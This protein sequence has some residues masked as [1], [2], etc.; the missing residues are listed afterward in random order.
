MLKGSSYKNFKNDHFLTKAAMAMLLERLRDVVRPK[1]NIGVVGLEPPPDKDD[2]EDDNE[3][4]DPPPLYTDL[5]GN[6]G[7]HGLNSMNSM[8][9]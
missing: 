7:P 2:N 9:E 5:F 1:N 4:D 3:D 8:N 6:T